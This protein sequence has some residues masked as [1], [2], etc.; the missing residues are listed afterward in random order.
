MDTRYWGP[1]GWRLLHL[2]SFGAGAKNA[3]AVCEFFQTLPY[4]L[5]CKYCRYSLSEYISKDPVDCAIRENRL[6]KWLWRIHNQVN[7]KLRK[8][9]LSTAPDA[10]FEKVEEVYKN[11]LA[12]GCSRTAFDGWE[13]LFSVAESHPLSRAAKLSFPISDH[14]PLKGLEAATPLERNKWNVMTAEERMPYYQRFWELLPEVFPFEEWTA[15]WY[16][17]AE[18]AKTDEMVCRRSDCLKGVWAIRKT[19]EEELELL[20][21][22]TYANLC[23]ELRYYR[24]GCGRKTC[25]RKRGST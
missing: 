15:A 12:A 24:T 9:K 23:K 13:F 14:P 25:R 18:A 7:A 21:K 2:V 22:T 11:R 16:K 6:E 3:K 19:M 8:Q 5:P 10:P 1:S 20:N 4:V 17:A